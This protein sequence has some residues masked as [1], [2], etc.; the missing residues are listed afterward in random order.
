MVTRKEKKMLCHRWAELRFSVVGGLLSSPPEP[1][2]LQNALQALSEK[3]WIHPKHGGP[4]KFGLS[5]IERWY[6]RAKDSNNP[7]DALQTPRR[8][9]AGKGRVLGP[10][11]SA[12]LKRQYE[13]HPGWSYDLHHENLKVIAGGD[14]LKYGRA[15]SYSTVRRHMRASGL[16][17]KHRPKHPKPGQIV[18]VER[19]EKR[20]VRSYEMAHVGALAHLDFHNGS[21]KVVDA[22]GQWHTPEC[23]ASLDDYSRLCLHCQWYLEEETETLVH[24]FEQALMKRGLPRM[25]MSDRGAAMMSGCFQ[26]G[27]GGLSIEHTPTLSYSPYQNAK[28]EHFWTSIEGQLCA[29]LEN[30]ED[31]TLDDLN[32]YTQ[33]W[34]EQGYNHHFHEEIL[35]TPYER[36]RDGPDVLRPSPDTKTLRLAFS[37]QVTRK[38][39]KS[40]GTISLDGIRFELPN[41]LRTLDTVTIRYRSWN[42]ASASV[43]D[44]RT[45]AE[46]AHILPLDKQRNASGFRRVFDEPGL[47]AYP[48]KIEDAERVAPLLEKMLADYAATGLPPAYVP[49]DE[50]T[51]AKKG[52]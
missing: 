42:L 28:Q 16:T 12:A 37:D 51:L 17:K 36:F 47:T 13:L 35:C 18:A 15:P 23:F 39:R 33:A 38:Q 20:E 21:L 31:L 50:L 27:L 52:E 43:I 14:P 7:I 1:G 41:R 48:K 29:M 8:L 34:V 4:V 11:L 25:L 45:H 22:A 5:T 9:D 49:K 32:V 2:E 24:G 30:V 40:D 19:L 44:P 26:N 3:E 10:E 6:Y 46:L